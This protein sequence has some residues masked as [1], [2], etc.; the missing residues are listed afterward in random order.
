MGR[1]RHLIHW[2]WILSAFA[3][4]LTTTAGAAVDDPY[5]G[6]WHFNVA[7]Y[8]WLPAISGSV[9]TDVSVPG[10]NGGVR[11]LDVNGSVNPDS[12][13]EN[14]QMALMLSAEA[15]KGRWSI[16]TD[17]V[18]VDFGSQDTEVRSVTGPDGVFSSEIARNAKVSVSAT[19][20]TLAGGY[21]VALE[22]TWN[23]DLIA[24][25]RY[26]TMD[27][28]LNLNL[29]DER[30]RYLAATKK[31]MDQDVWDAII[32]ARGQIQFQD[33]RWFMPYYADI[34]TGSSNWT[35]QAM[36]GLG[37]RFGWG[38]AT[39]AWRALGYEFDDGDVDM[40][41]SGP[42]LGVGFRW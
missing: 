37:Y 35:W 4:A 10:Q 19:I 22:P 9:D 8:L 27:S 13:L 36:L 18:Y 2:T 14:L 17:V 32:G 7:P 12:Y 29:Q 42:G 34:G 16:L 33:T 25:F 24:G 20:W 28:A 3:L 31:S 26:L 21:T 1:S 6:N 15:R 23:L 39:L 5:D 38:E 40:T 11:R 30:G 41:F